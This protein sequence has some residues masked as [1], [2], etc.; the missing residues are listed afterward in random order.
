MKQ[1]VDQLADALRVIKTAHANKY[2]DETWTEQDAAAQEMGSRALAAH[3]APG[4]QEA[5]SPVA[6][7][8]SHERQLVE[9]VRGFFWAK[10]NGANVELAERY[11]ATALASYGDAPAAAPSED[12]PEGPRP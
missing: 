11:L 2:H 8:S 6:E 5:E 9:A 12:E 1:R 10:A 7:L 4:A 3:D